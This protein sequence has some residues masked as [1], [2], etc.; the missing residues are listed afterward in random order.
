MLGHIR[1]TTTRG[2]LSVT[3]EW[4]QRHYAKGIKVSR[5]EMAG[6]EIEHH[7]TCPQW[8]YTFTPRNAHRWN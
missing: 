6:L 2:G 7:D 3:A 4:W 1:G 5:Q 8:N